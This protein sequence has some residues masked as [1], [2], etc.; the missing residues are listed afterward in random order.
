MTVV[1]NQIDEIAGG[2]RFSMRIDIQVTEHRS[3]PS[4]LMTK[5]F[6]RRLGKKHKRRKRIWQKREE[7]LTAAQIA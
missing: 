1:I 7:M 4:Q 2:L 5:P 6:S 3:V